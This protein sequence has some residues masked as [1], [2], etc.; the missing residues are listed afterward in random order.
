MKNGKFLFQGNADVYL[1]GKNALMPEGINGVRPISYF[2]GSQ[3]S[4]L[5]VN[6]FRKSPV[7]TAKKILQG[8]QIDNFADIFNQPAKIEVTEIPGGISIDLHDKLEGDNIDLPILWM[9][10]LNSD[11]MPVRE[12]EWEYLNV[13][14]DKE[15][16]FVALVR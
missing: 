14:D 9:G 11:Y 1:Q 10:I 6:D 2:I 7:E 13:T 3:S 4:K 8:E 12:T 5:M 15:V 16:A